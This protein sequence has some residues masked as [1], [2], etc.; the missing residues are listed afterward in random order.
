MEH[1]KVVILGAGISGICAGINLKAQGL[2][3]FRIFEKADEVGGTWRDNRYPGV[4]CDVPS[5][6]YS[7][8]FEL[9]P[10]WSRDYAGGAE[11]FGYLKDVTQ[12]YGLYDDITFGTAI[13]Y[14]EFKDGRWLLR[15]NKGEMFSADMLISALGF[16]HVPNIPAL[17]GLEDFNGPCF[18]TSQWDHSVSFEGKRVAIIGTG[19]TSVQCAPRLADVAER[20]LVFQRTPVWVGPKVNRAIADEEIEEL[21]QNPAALRKRR[22]D[23]WNGWETNGLALVTEGTLANRTAERK[24]LESLRRQVSDPLLR[25]KLIPSYNMFCKRPTLSNEYYSM[26]TRDNVDLITSGVSQIGPDRIIASDDEEHPVDII[27]MATGFKSFDIVQEIDLRGEDGVTLKDVW[28]PH[29]TTYKTIMAPRMPNFFFVLGP[30]SGGLTSAFQ[31]IE[32]ASSYISLLIKYVDDHGYKSVTAK[33][34]KI[35]EFKEEILESFSK[36]TQNKGCTSWWTDETGYP[37]A[38]WPDSSV[39]Y[40]SML[41]TLVPED[42]QFA[43]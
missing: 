16:L 30:N 17:P 28:S 43:R 11:I 8:S 34:E 13:E 37:H 4:E 27:V 20:V 9:K 15:S 25:E 26:F 22:W 14:A 29:I 32:A 36:T 24:A 39:R 18:H 7:F 41:H 38:N 1:Y 23:L 21:S 40:R 5:H 35:Q 42:F 19:A 12:K 2:G 33:A 3:P 31:M 10:D 6:L